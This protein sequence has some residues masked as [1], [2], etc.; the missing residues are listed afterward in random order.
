MGNI[1]SAKWI[2][3]F[4]RTVRRIAITYNEMSVSKV[5]VPSYA[6]LKSFPVCM[7]FPRDFGFG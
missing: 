2:A 1:I 6:D 4:Q 5:A 3:D 7:N